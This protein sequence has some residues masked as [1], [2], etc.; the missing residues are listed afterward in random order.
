MILL[1]FSHPITE[2]QQGQIE[3]ALNM[4]IARDK[5]DVKDIPCQMDIGAPFG[6]QVAALADACGFTPSEWQTCRILV[7]LPALSTAAA[8]LLAE[9]HGRCGFYPPAIRFKQEDGV[10]PPR[11]VL[12]EV[13]DVNGQR[14]NARKRR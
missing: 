13:M 8:L 1:N 12:A 10:V 4:D 5:L 3:R 2:K 7:N 14:Q 11:Y 9:L 6:D